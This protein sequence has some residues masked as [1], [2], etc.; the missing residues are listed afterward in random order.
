M[1]LF[2]AYEVEG[3][4]QPDTMTSDLASQC[5]SIFN[6]PVQVDLTTE[7]VNGKPVIAVR[8]YEA[9][10]HD[11]PIFFVK[12]GLPK[13]A[14]RRIGSTDQHCTDDDLVLLY[15]G[16]DRESYDQSI[17]FDATPDDL[18][19][20]AIKDYR[21][22]RA[23]TTPDAEELRWSDE[24]L[25]RALGCTRRQEERWVPTVAGIV[26]FG[27]PQALRRLFPMTRVDYIRVPGH[28]WVP[29]PER[30]FDSIELRD[31]M[32]RLIRPR[33]RRCSMTCPR[34]STWQRA[35]F[36]AGTSR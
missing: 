23:E 36:S 27:T 11:K 16:R 5:R 24:D 7:E 10:A 8:V 19:A 22:S 34:R 9:P 29:H 15:R 31:S 28:A 17:V 12:Q 33:R 14:L 13:G 32:F 25:L 21:Q 26:L 2:P 18:S 1:A 30:R 4:D 3:I 35:I 6:K 20:D